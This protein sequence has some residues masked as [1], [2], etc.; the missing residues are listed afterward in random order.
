V[1]QGVDPEFKPQYLN[2]KKK[3]REKK[4]EEW[5]WQPRHIASSVAMLPH[6]SPDNCK[7]PSLP[8]SLPPFFLPWVLAESQLWIWYCPRCGKCSREW[9][10]ILVIAGWVTS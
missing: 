6:L 1:A 10:Q 2:K 9:N 5:V 8:S 3:E 4:G 7:G